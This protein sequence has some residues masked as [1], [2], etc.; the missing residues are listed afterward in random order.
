MHT[1][2]LIV[3]VLTAAGLAWDAWLSR[4]SERQFHRPL[5]PAV[6]DVYDRDRYADFRAYH[7]EHERLSRASALAGVAITLAALVAPYFKWMDQ[8]LG[9]RPYALAFWSYAL[10]WV[11]KTTAETI[12]SYYDVFVIEARYGQNR[13]TRRAFAKDTALDAAESLAV[14]GGGLMFTTWLLSR[15]S[16]WTGGGLSAGR[17]VLAAGIVAAILFA[18]MLAAAGLELFVLTRQYRLTPLPEGPL[19]DQIMALQ[20]GVKRPI[21]RI[22]VYNES[23]KSTRKNAFMFRF[24]GFKAFGIADNFLSGNSERELLAVL[25]HEIGH[26]KHKR[27]LANFVPAILAAAGVLLLALCCARP[28]LPR[29]FDFWARRC[30]GLAHTNLML[31]FALIKLVASPAAAALSVWHNFRSRREEKEADMEAVGNG[32]GAELIATFKRL[33]RDQLVDVNPDPTVEA[34]TYD[35]PGM[36]ARIAYIEKAMADQ[37]DHLGQK[38]NPKSMPSNKNK[39]PR[40]NRR[41]FKSVQSF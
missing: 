4:R 7:A 18:G 23:A 26:L 33:S 22:L 15:L 21:T 1:A 30:Y 13:R 5:P 6:A 38:I 10:I 24:F 8:A 35:H 9:A 20:A 40:A 25:S 32:Y 27:T 2:Q 16:A 28:G 11:V 41:L 31:D 37:A 29:A 17:A 39:N 3:I 34:L 14:G 12:F 36:A 19:R